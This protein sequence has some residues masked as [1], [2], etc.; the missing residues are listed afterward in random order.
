[1][2]KTP[3]KP[4][5]TDVAHR[6]GVSLSTV[7]R[8]MNGNATVDA[9]MAERV[10]AAASEL[11][12]T[13]NPLARSLVLGRTQTIAVVVP[14][15][16][17]PTFQEIL[18]GLSR[19]AA[20]DGYHVL[21]A[22]SAEQ[23][24]E[25]PVLATETRRRTDGVVLCAPRMTDDDLA[26]LLPTLTPVVVI[27]RP[28]QASAPVVGA[29]YRTAFRTVVD[30]LYGRG[31]RHLIYLAGLER[32]ASNAA[33]RAALADARAA[34]ADLVVDEIPCGVDFD[35][36]SGAADAVSASGATG[37]LAFNDLV[38]MGLLSALADRG[39]RVPQDISVAGFDDIPFAQYTTP[40]LTTSAVPGGDLGARAWAAM[41]AQLT[42]GEAD[43]AVALTPRLLVRGSTGPAPA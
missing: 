21:I 32:S 15:L 30:H 34:H 17:N 39:I 43:A 14:D 37:A 3:G 35:S 25:E 2:A 33:R 11:G 38:A 42:G 41:K 20:A 19:A 5:I 10:R 12:Y 31:H 6:A 23:V 29:D 1:M 28:A 40:P 26:A 7:S 13:A 16:A 24:A 22:D 18:R 8:V 36:G 9:E 27:N 4:T